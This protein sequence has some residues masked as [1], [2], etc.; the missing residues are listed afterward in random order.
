MLIINY[1]LLSL[2]EDNKPL[3]EVVR[4]KF[5]IISISKTQRIAGTLPPICAF[6]SRKGGIFPSR[7]PHCLENH[8]SG[9]APAGIRSGQSREHNY[10]AKN[11]AAKLEWWSHISIREQGYST[12]NHVVFLDYVFVMFELVTTPHPMTKH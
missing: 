9:L 4:K 12:I 6:E 10:Q 3:L 5:K 8:N 11:P 2:H 1:Q 7:S